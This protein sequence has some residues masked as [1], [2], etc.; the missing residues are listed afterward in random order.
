MRSVI[1]ASF[2]DPAGVLHVEERPVPAPGPGEIRVRMKLAP[3]HNHDLFMI[4]GQYGIKPPLPATGGSEALG[5]VDAL[6]EG[7]TAPAIGQRVTMTGLGGAWT[8]YFVAPAA[9]A[10][11]LP[12][13]V[14]DEIGCQISAMPMSAMMAL[15]DLGVKPGEWMIQNAATGAVGKTLAMIA[16]ARGIRVVNLV[17]REAGI[18]ELAAVGVGEAVSTGDKDWPAEVAE[19]TGG[20]P[21]VAALDSVGG[22]ESGQLLHLLANGG[23]LMS[24]GAMGGKPM[25]LNPGDLIFKQATVK[26][27]WG[28]KRSAALSREEAARMMGELLRLASTG[29]LKLPLEKS[30]DLSEAGAAAR[31][32]A[33]PGRTGKIAFR[34]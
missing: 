23:T 8:E 14:S 19:I 32:S 33:E 4:R 34:A 30:F 9:R 20:A 24:F 25:M 1:Y 3:I 18:A 21:I 27:F 11:P 13:A 16:T 2:G 31:A 10:V 17:R 7:V 29:A 6:G 28:S 5:I 22:E 12:D 26:G 15:A